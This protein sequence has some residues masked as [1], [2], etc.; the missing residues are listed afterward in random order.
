M[1]LMQKVLSEEQV[2]I[3][4]ETELDKRKLFLGAAGSGKTF[5]AIEKSRQLAAEGKKVLTTC[6]NKSLASYLASEL[7]RQVTVA[8]IHDFF[9]NLAF[10]HGMQ[11]TV[12]SEMDSR[13]AFYNEILPTM[14]FD[15]LAD[16]GDDK[17]FDAIIVDE[18]QDFRIEWFDCLELAL[19]KDGVF[20][21]FADPAQSIFHN[22]ID[23]ITDL[24]VSKH[25]LTQNF[26]NTSAINDWMSPFIKGKPLRSTGKQGLPVIHI[27]YNTQSEEVGLIEKEVGRLV[28]QGI[29]LK[30]IQILSPHVKKKSCLAERK[31]LKEWP[32][33]DVAATQ[34]YGV[35]FATI[36]SFKGLEADIVFLID[37]NPDDKACTSA[38][39]YVGGS[40]ARFLLYIFHDAR[41]DIKNTLPQ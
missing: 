37:I 34:Q 5:V 38:D 2:R 33:V 41:H 24:P 11:V 25:K 29:Q 20:F 31:K 19:E 16:A 7:P 6:F 17:H 30:R 10:E 40:R 21:V 28:S 3:L 23:K 8:P 12:P 39:I 9:M 1:S 15:C 18:G 22:D 36:R 13:S 14:A 35:S 27:P 4:E 32:L 26:R